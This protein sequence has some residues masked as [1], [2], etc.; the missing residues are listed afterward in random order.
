MHGTS[1]ESGFKL[2]REACTCISI[3][4]HKR[5]ITRLSAVS[6][7]SREMVVPTPI[8]CCAHEALLKRISAVPRAKKVS[9]NISRY[10]SKSIRLGTPR[11]QQHHFSLL[12]GGY[13][14]DIIIT[15]S[16][17]VRA[18]TC[19]PVVDESVSRLEP[20]HG[21]GAAKNSELPTR[22]SQHLT[23]NMTPH[24]ILPRKT[25]NDATRWSV[26]GGTSIINILTGRS[27][28]R[29]LNRSNTF[30]PKFS[31]PTVR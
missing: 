2:T 28:R 20:S 26:S 16:C 19:I 23:R 14:P 27:T 11:Q 15:T 1:R 8:S 17:L 24:E 13:R 21:W 12:F 10:H 4:R 6:A 22:G 5:D 18:S 29:E 9:P 30:V 25:T 3:S 7:S 31:T